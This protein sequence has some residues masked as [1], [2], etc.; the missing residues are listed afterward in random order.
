MDMV[1]LL[2]TVSRALQLKLVP[3]VQALDIRLVAGQTSLEV[4]VQDIDNISYGAHTGHILPEGVVAAG[5]KGVALNHSENKALD[6]EELVGKHARAREVGLKTLVFAGSMDELSQMI[7]LSPDFVAYEPPELIGSQNKSVVTEE[8]EII[9]NA[10]ELA[11]SKSLPLIVG[12]GIHT[13]EDIKISLSLG[14]SGFAVA[15]GIMQA[16]NPRQAVEDLVKGYM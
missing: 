9:K 1:R 11:Q 14:A 10:V 16:Q 5:A 15:S 3:V 7:V 12:A 13:Q 2:E 6:F 8:P 4:W